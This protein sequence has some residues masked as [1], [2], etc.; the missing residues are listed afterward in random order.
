MSSE[1]S[2]KRGRQPGEEKT[3]DR[4]DPK[5]A[6]ASGAAGPI[7][8]APQQPPLQQQQQPVRYQPGRPPEGYYQPMYPPTG[9]GNP[10]PPP[11]GYENP[12]P[13]HYGMPPY[14]HPPMSPYMPPYPP[15]QHHPMYPPHPYPQHPHPAHMNPY[16]AAYPPPPEHGMPPNMAHRYG[17]VPPPQYGAPVVP[18]PPPTRTT[19][20]SAADGSGGE[21]EDRK[22]AARGGS[23]ED[24]SAEGGDD[25][26]DD[27]DDDDEDK[28]SSQGQITPGANTARLKTYIKPRA[29]TTQDVLDRRSRKNLQSRSRAAKLRDRISE[30]EVKPVEERNEEE[31]QIWAQYEARRQRK[32]DRS[33]ERAIEKKEEIDR[34]LNK[35]DK[36]RSKIEK[37][38]LE[39]ALGAKKR[40]NEGDRL[41]RQRLK[42]LGLKTKGTGV[43]PGI[44][45]RGPLPAQYSATGTPTY[46]M[47]DIPM[48]PLP[49]TGMPP[50]ALH[51]HPHHG[52]PPPHHHAGAHMGVSPGT[53]GSPGSGGMP[54]H[55]PSPHHPQQRSSAA[56]VPGVM[57]TSSRSRAEPS[58]SFVPPSQAASYDSGVGGGDR[59]A[60]DGDPNV[61]RGQLHMLPSSSRVE[62][63]RNPDGSMSI[64]IGRSSGNNGGSSGGPSFGGEARMNSEEPNMSDVSH[65]LLYDNGDGEENGGG[66]GGNGGG[67]E[68]RQEDEDDDEEG[69]KEE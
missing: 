64:S 68:D 27:D 23:I 57:E 48:S 3:E 45:A 32:N 50:H 56:A 1:W 7:A 30:I 60:G 36:K 55:Y 34:I 46:G 19:P 12:P 67:A 65:L 66:G 33:R 51:H 14:G 52:P 40:K 43:K 58:M 5:Q 22:P 10:Y 41:R 13:P 69:E 38:F 20:S 29:P 28:S 6:S 26:D 53:F 49:T 39:T 11:R 18:P 15:Y 35:Q 4:G 47:S 63:R 8:A 61:P 42:S 54:P 2:R 44:S 37:Q 16:G 9:E 62:Q 17:E 59:V 25:G 21:R 24:P 31:H